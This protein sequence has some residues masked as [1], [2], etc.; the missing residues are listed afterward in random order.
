MR[1]K[2]PWKGYQPI[3]LHETG[4]TLDGMPVDHRQQHRNPEGHVPPST[5]FG[6][7]H[8]PR[9]QTFILKLH[10]V[11]TVS[12]TFLCHW[13]QG[14][15]TITQQGQFRDCI[16]PRCTS[17]E[18]RNTLKKKTLLTPHM[19]LGSQSHPYRRRKDTAVLSAKPPRHTETQRNKRKSV[20]GLLWKQPLKCGLRA[21]HS[22]WHIQYTK[23]DQNQPDSRTPVAFGL[24]GS[25][26]VPSHRNTSRESQGA[27]TLREAD[28]SMKV[29]RI[30]PSTK[31][32]HNWQEQPW[33]E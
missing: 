28:I 3:T 15:D 32:S 5:E 25:L 12:N 1:Q 29:L 33:V 21:W 23:A 20:C 13:S 6:F 18:K 14:V 7:I 10:H 27:W 2:T 16:L 19:Q 30:W 4:D 24:S 11:P 17:F 26:I 31:I 8:P 9:K 22:Q